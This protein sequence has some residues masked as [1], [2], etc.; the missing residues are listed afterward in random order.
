MQLVAIGLIVVLSSLLYTAMSY[1]LG[2]LTEPTEAYLRQYVQEDFSVEMMSVLTSEEAQ[3]PIVSRQVSQRNFALAQ[4]RQSE[5]ATFQ[6]LIDNRV[7]EFEDAYPGTSLE[8]R[9]T[10]TVE[11]ERG[12]RSHTALVARDA[13]HINLSFIES[14]A[15]P[16]RDNE[17]AL[18]R[19]YAQKNGI[20]IGDL[21]VMLGRRY[22]VTGYVLFP[23]YTLT[24]FDNSLVIDTGLQA[25][26]LLS[27]SAFDAVDADAA[28]RLA[29]IS[30][31]GAAVDTAIDR[32][33]VPFVTQIIPTNS[34]MR[35]GAIYS[36]LTQGRTTSLGLSIFIAAIAVVIVSIMMSDLLG[37]ERGQ[38]GILKALGYRRNE[39][40]RP[41]FVAMMALALVMLILGYVLG[42]LLA[43]PLKRMYLDFYLLPQI[44]ITQT[45]AVFTAAV[46]VPLL[47][48]A[49]SAGAVIFR[50][51]SE[52]PLALLQPREVGYVNTLT[53]WMS[54]LLSRA[55]G[56]TRFK[57]L[58]AVR[59][60]GSFIVFFVGIMFSTLLILYALMMNGMVDRMTV[61][62]LENLGYRYQAIV[63]P[64][65][66]TPDPRPGDERFLLYPYAYLGEKVVTL[67]GLEPGN[68]LTNLHD[69]DGRN[70]TNRIRDNAVITKSLA[71]K[72]GLERGDRIGVRVNDRQ[73][74][75]TVAGVAAEYSSDTVYLNISTLSGIL[76]NGESTRL[77]SGI[78]SIDKPS[79]QFY[80]AIVSKQGMIDQSRTMANYTTVMINSMILTSA[81][82]AASILFVLT[83]FT[84]ERNYYPI[85]LLK[86]LGY[87]R[88]EVNSMILNSYFVYSLIA[89]ALSVPLTLVVLRGL[90][91]V[92]LRGYGLVLPLEFDPLDA[93]KALAFLVV[94]FVVGTHA[95]RR[96]IA[97][98]PLQEVLKT[99]AE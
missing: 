98:I 30:P 69:E 33:R 81:L 89:F 28:F 67:H 71:L 32:D 84:V 50:M 5:P 82:I 79:P 65:K 24:T 12:G 58:H 38:I 88:T 15:K 51:L 74:E 66:R 64:T 16:Q 90:V 97:R 1:A 17:I 62:P 45:V 54:R 73:H 94:I 77:Y 4:I 53:R 49:V 44:E 19:V 25:L 36:E 41:Y 86:V 87:S 39:V 20:D 11:F 46:F 80:R 92:F 60:T 68:A 70:I 37:A 83:S 96:K 75:F 95:S 43:D 2:S 93:L 63:D 3:L 34:N 61:G 91:A 47:F 23:D 35:S 22:L 40:A 57:Y 14:G 42:V 76:T 72:R 13:E 7:A 48:F 21:F 26:V 18:N 6:R 52:G 55:K 85:S 27:N 10:K 29:G 99:Y 56:S 31:G 59:N 8:L 78:Y 9:Q